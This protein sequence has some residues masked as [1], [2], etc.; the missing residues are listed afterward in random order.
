MKYINFFVLGFALAVGSLA[1]NDDGLGV[2]NNGKDLSAGGGDIKP[3]DLKMND[4]G[5]GPTTPQDLKGVSC[6]DETCNS[7]QQCCVQPTG[8]QNFSATCVGLGG[9]AD[10]GL[11]ASCDGP[12]DCSVSGQGC[13]VDV[14]VSFGMMSMNPS[15]S[16]GASCNATCEANAVVDTGAGSADIQSALCHKDA[17]CVG[18][19]GDVDAPFIGGM[20]QAFNKC[21]KAMQGGQSLSFCAPEGVATFGSVVGIDCPGI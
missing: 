11:V 17:D 21:C 9:C 15:G 14:T 7:S 2:N 4:P 16:G 19:V 10:G 5:D 6:G 12:E 20:N 13:C 18:L 1:C 8:G 3:S